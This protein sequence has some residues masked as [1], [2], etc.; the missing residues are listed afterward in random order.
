MDLLPTGESAIR[1][2]V[3]DFDLCPRFSALVFEGVKVEPSPLWLQ[4]RLTA[5]G[6]NPINNIVDLTNFIMAELAQPMHA[7]DRSLIKG[8][9]LR[10]R[11]AK[12]G[13]SVLALNKESYSATSSNLVIADEGGLWA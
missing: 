13:E 11:L 7:Y 8:G 6:L 12:P 3:E 10:A 4:Y 9:V 1:I 2:E 5:V